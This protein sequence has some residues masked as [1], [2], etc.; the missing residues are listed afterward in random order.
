MRNGNLDHPDWG[1]WGGRYKKVR[2]NTWLDPVPDSTY[3]YAE[4]RWYTET[5]W[6]RQY[7][8]HEYPNHKDLMEKYFNPIARWTDTFQNDFAARADWCVKSY[9]EGS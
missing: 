5:G 6:G 3:Q 2:A 8:K 1:S 7:M 4:G 9:K